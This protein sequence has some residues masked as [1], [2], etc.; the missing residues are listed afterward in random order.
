M[1]ER[2][3]VSVYLPTRNRAASVE[4]AIRSVLQQDYPRFELL[5]VDDASTDDTAALLDRLSS[6]DARL[7]FFRQR[8]PRGAGV[9]RNVAIREARGEFVTGLDDDDLMLPHRLTS[10]IG[11]CTDAHAFAC[12]AFYVVNERAG[13]YEVRSPV[14]EEISLARLL[15]GNVIG[16]QAMLRTDR[17]RAIGAFDETLPAWQDYDLWTR[18][19]LEYGP[20]LRVADPTYVFFESADPRR[21]T[22]SEAASIGARLYAEKFSD[23]MGPGQLKAQRFMQVAVQRRRLTL[24]EAR[25]CW[26]DATKERIAGYWVRSNLPWV[27]R[28]ADAVKRRRRPLRDLPAT[29]RRQLP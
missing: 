25:A 14:R 8:E 16:N 24:A 6:G 13:W 11:A 20:A 17:V 18:M 10:L 1:N 5:V 15:A 23:R 29:V 27:E 2:P 28:L 22:N 12:S 21:I 3:L 9:A 4:R 19:V 7:R 26:D